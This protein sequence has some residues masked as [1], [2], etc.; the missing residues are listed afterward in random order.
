MTSIMWYRL[1][2]LTVE[3]ICVSTFRLVS[4]NREKER[5]TI[6]V[7][8]CVCTGGGGVGEGWAMCMSSNW[9]SI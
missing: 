4:Y 1:L 2:I 9:I 6:V 8:V 3:S 7:C 5:E